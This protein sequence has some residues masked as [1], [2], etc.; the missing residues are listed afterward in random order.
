[1]S[2]P[3]LKLNTGATIPAIG[4][5]DRH[6]R[7]E[8]GRLTISLGLGV[9]AGWEQSERDAAKDWI[10]T[11]LKVF[12]RN[13]P[14]DRLLNDHGTGWLSPPRHRL[15]L[16]YVTSRFGVCET[17]SLTAMRTGTEKSVGGAIRESGVPREEIFVTTK[18]A[19]VFY[20][21][22][23]VHERLV[24]YIDSLGSVL[25]HARAEEAFKESLENLGLDYVDLVSPRSC[26]PGDS[27]ILTGMPFPVSHPLAP[28]FQV[29]TRR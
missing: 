26:V 22:I 14:V 7:F 25:H 21:P 20:S 2:I 29:Y 1:M 18:L 4:M 28:S 13:N 16:R 12:T 27:G 15:V 5:Y 23:L 3:S 11:A 24:D 8:I 9:F 10:L 17:I 6:D 19:L